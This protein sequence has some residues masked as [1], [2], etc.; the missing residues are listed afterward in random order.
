MRVCFA[1]YPTAF[2]QPGGGE[3]VLLSL[4]EALRDYVDEVQFFDPW[5]T[6]LKDYEVLHYFSSYGSDQFVEW[7]RHVGLLAVT[8]FIW[9]ELPHRVHA[10]RNVRRAARRLTRSP[11][12]EPFAA[13][14]ILFPTSTREAQLLHENYRVPLERLV[15]VPHGADL[16]FADPPSGAFVR[17]SEAERYVLCP[18]RIEPNKN[19]L[20]V[21]HALADTDVEL[22]VLGGVAPGFESYADACRAAAGPRTCFLHALPHESEEL[23]D[24]IVSAACV[25]IGSRYELCSVAALE[26]G[27]AGVPLASTNGGGM[28]EHLTPFAEF[29]DPADEAQIRRAVLQALERGRRPGQKEHFAARFSWDAIARRTAAAYGERA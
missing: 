22:I 16:R 4:A 24:A 6:R 28:L 13:A 21:V 23:R 2:Q 3:Q 17:I 15:V 9:P 25:V 29:F 14:D 27:L 8:P 18:G 20:R 5:R 7:R 11:A 19:Q 1:A 10:L 26:A 12:S